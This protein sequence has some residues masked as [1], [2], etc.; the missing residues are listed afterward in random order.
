MKHSDGV[1]SEKIKPRFD[2]SG[3]VSDAGLILTATLTD[4]LE[5][6]KL[7]GETLDFGSRP[8]GARPE[9]KAMTFKQTGRKQWIQTKADSTTAISTVTKTRTA[10]DRRRCANAVQS[11]SSFALR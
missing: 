4:R 9:R 2:D 11:R 1:R 6:V 8:G 3:L 10:C 7:I 5:L